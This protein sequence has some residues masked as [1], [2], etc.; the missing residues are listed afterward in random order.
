MAGPGDEVATAE[1]RGRGDLRASDADREQVVDALRAAFLQGRLTADELGARAD[2]VYASRTYAD[3]T[4]VIADIPTALTGAPSPRPPWRA[5]K[6]AL[7]FEYAAF[8]PGIVAVIVLPGG[9]RTTI[10]TF[11]IFAAVIYPVFWL[12]GLLKMIAA[13]RVTPAA[14]R[15]PGP[16]PA[17]LPQPAGFYH[18]EQVIRPALRAALAQ[19]LLTVDEFDAREA[20]V[21][22]SRSRA[23]MAP[24]TADL[25]V[26]LTTRLPRPRDAWTGVCA[27]VAAAGV[28]AALLHWQPGNSPAFLL[29]LFSAATILLVPPITVGLMFDA[30]HQKR[31]GRQLRLGSAPRAGGCSGTSGCSSQ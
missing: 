4:E 8:L 17:G 18:A 21:S 13:R 3:L 23:E 1:D 24:L 6:R 26:G 2:R 10:W 5:A 25:P 27:T 29:A 11:I 19:G 30:R 16:P 22:E 15:E 28:L 20:Q 31:V 12:F 9:P 7:W 14:G